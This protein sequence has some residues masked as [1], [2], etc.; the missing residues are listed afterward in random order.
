[1]NVQHTP[2]KKFADKLDEMKKAAENKDNTSKTEEENKGE[3]EKGNPNK[4]EENKGEPEKGNPIKEDS[5]DDKNQ[6]DSEN[7]STDDDKKVKRMTLLVNMWFNHKPLGV[8]DL[9]DEDNDL[10]FVAAW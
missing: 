9:D 6:D 2:I 10:V 3:P 8:E 1:M 5:K 7:K 4:K